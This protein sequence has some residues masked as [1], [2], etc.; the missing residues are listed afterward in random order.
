M[1]D[2]EQTRGTR[3]VVVRSVVH[4]VPVGQGSAESDVVQMRADDHILVFQRGV[5]ALD[6]TDD[7]LGMVLQVVHRHFDVQLLVAGELEGIQLGVIPRAVENLLRG[8]RLALEHR[9]GERQSSGD[10]W[11][12]RARRGSL[13]FHRLKRRAVQTGS[14]GAPATAARGACRVG[15]GGQLLEIGDRHN[16]QCSVLRAVLLGSHKIGAGLAERIGSRRA[17]SACAAAG[18]GLC[19]GVSRARRR[20]RSCGAR[21]A[22]AGASAA[23]AA[24]RLLSRELG[25]LSGHHDDLTLHVDSLIRIDVAFVDE[26]AVAGEHE[27]GGSIQSLYGITSPAATTAAAAE[28][29]PAARSYRACR[30]IL[31]VIKIRGT[32][33]RSRR[34]GAGGSAA[35]RAPTAS[36]PRAAPARATAARRGRRTG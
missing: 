24:R 15:H 21:T 20:I 18:R 5:A 3:A 33:F 9:V 30:P 29:K 36:S 17:A 23:P 2:A 12:R 14:A 8:Y 25:R 11:D 13:E 22:P 4:V 19:A 32:D 10:R 35:P 16:A 6:D 7:I 1:G 34:G 28:R 27:V 31:A 26:V